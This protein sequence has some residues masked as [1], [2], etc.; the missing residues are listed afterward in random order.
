MSEIVFLGCHGNGF[1]KFWLSLDLFLNVPI[2][3]LQ[4][5]IYSNTKKRTFLYE[6]NCLSRMLSSKV[7]NN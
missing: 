4:N 3:A 7:M 5:S 6:I 1:V 2:N